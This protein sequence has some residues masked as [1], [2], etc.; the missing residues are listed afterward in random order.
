MCLPCLD[1]KMQYH[2]Y[3]DERDIEK[4]YVLNDV[5]LEIDGGEEREGR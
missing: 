3:I 4:Q 1:E 2:Y 5:Q